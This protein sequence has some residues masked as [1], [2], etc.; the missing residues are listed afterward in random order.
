MA[1]PVITMPSRGDHSAPR[2]DTKQPRELRHY[3]SD[4]KYCF[5]QAQIVDDM[6]KKSHTCRFV[7]INT[8]ELW[9][10]LAKFADNTKTYTDFCQITYSLYPGS[11]EERKWSIADM[12]KLVGEQSCLG[13]LLLGDLGEYCTISTASSVMHNIGQ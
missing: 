9:E 4:L 8:S 5:E 1:A 6:E 12:D 13:V 3:F 11:E 2:F 10:S 7:N